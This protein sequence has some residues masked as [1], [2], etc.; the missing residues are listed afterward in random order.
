MIVH[1]SS[2]S[3]D[4]DTGPPR[5][6]LVDEDL[7]FDQFYAAQFQRLTLQLYAY[8]ADVAQAQ[9]V[10]QEAFCR[11]LARWDKIAKFD[12]PVAWVRRVAWNLANSRFRRLRVAQAHA[13]QQRTEHVEGPGPD[14]VALARALATLP[15]SHRR[16][17]VLFHLAD[18][19]V[20]EIAE[21]EGVA[22]GTVKAWLHRGRAALA[23]QLSDLG[24]ERRNA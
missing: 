21:Q 12:D 7:R 14:R 19:S 9:D 15:A 11:A 22:T 13:R 10:V 4:D 3:S 6:V 17:V 2:G 8:T 24:T 16:A 1:E 18:L 20:S 23:V 5:T